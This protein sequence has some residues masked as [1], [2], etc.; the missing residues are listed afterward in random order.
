MKNKMKFP[1]ALPLLLLACGATSLASCAANEVVEDN[2]E[3]LQLQVRNAATAALGDNHVTA[4]YMT[5]FNPLYG[6]DDKIIEVKTEE[7]KDV[8]FPEDPQRAGYEFSGWSTVYSPMAKAG[9]P[10]SIVKSLKATENKVL[11]GVWRKSANPDDPA[12]KAYMDNLRETS[13]PNHLYYH[14]YRFDNSPKSYADWDVWAWAYKPTAGE[15]AKFD[16]YGRTQSADHMSATGD[17]VCEDVAGAYVD[18]DLSK[19]YDGG[20]NNKTYKMGGTPVSYVGAEQIGLQIVQTKTR[21]SASGFWTN[22]G[23]NLFIKLSDYALALN[24]GGEAYHVFVVQDDVQEPSATPQ[25]GVEDPFEGDDG[26]NVTYGNKDYDQS[27]YALANKEKTSEAFKD[28]GVGYQIMVSSFADSDGDGSGDIYGIVK[29][30]DYIQ[31]LGVKAIWLTPVQLSDSY[32]GYDITDYEKVDP[33]FGSAVSPAAQANNGEVTSETAMADYQLL[34]EEAHKRGM[35]VVMDLVLNHT[36]TSNKWFVRSANLD[37]D[38]RGYYQWGNHNTQSA[39]KPANYWYPYGDHDYSYYAKFGSAMPELNFSYK[40]TREAVED[41]SNFWAGTVGVDGF[42]LDAVKHI[43]MTDEVASTSG[44][45]IINDVSVSGNYSSDLTKNLNFFRELKAK[46][47]NKEGKS[48]FFVGE[49]FDG[50]AYHVAPYY[51]A[52]DSLFDFY[53]YFNLTSAAATGRKNSTSG[54]GTASGFLWNGSTYSIAKDS[55]S[56]TGVRDSHGDMKTADGSAWNFPAVYATYNKYRGDVSLPG[57]FTSNHDIARVINRIA[58]TGTAEGLQAQG[59]ITPSNWADYEKS[60]DCVKIAE[61]MMPGLTWIYYGDELGMTGNF[62][63][64]SSMDGHFDYADLWYRQPM[65]WGD[66]YTTSF[67]VTGSSEQVRWD[68]VN[69]NTVP[70]AKT[71]VANASSEYNILKKFATL[72]SG[73]DAVAKALTIGSMK[74]ENFAWGDLAANVLSFSRTYNGTTIKV[75][76]NFNGTS[77]DANSLEGTVLASYNN[78]SNNRSTLPAY[79]AIIVKA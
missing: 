1:L 47:K 67:Y 23:S 5:T 13:Q 36:S 55:D 56:A 53:S 79:S 33:K 76:I 54:F 27:P 34:I 37:E 29:K 66:E 8:K 21:T 14:Y 24:N 17:A 77:I 43:F 48:V 19:T 12:V 45:T 72:K 41:M 61:L 16:W 73:G 35:K 3:G 49:N 10:A 50:H 57:L 58:G 74:A 25:A 69:E 20:W 52:F 7:G 39:I 65:K 2:N 26:T 40:S 71:Q 30:L 78:P 44:D 70:D 31:N 32:H 22:D 51:E 46:V 4:V 60:A 18:I 6:G 62:P 64:G 11:Y 68:A 9:D 75:A 42:R 59:N 63:N 15:G 28:V 38:Y